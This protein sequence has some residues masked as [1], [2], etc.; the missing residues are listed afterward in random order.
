MSTIAG[1]DS[2]RYDQMTWLYIMRL[3]CESQHHRTFHWPEEKS[4]KKKKKYKSSKLS[5]TL[6]HLRVSGVLNWP[7][8][9]MYDY[10]S[11]PLLT[12][13]TCLQVL[14]IFLTGQSGSLINKLQ[15]VFRVP[16]ER[17]GVHG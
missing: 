3:P 7:Y 4:Q 14:P 10:T 17:C 16:W 9:D 15:K 5:G 11:R 13:D 2:G 8:P 1:G 6:T 12:Y